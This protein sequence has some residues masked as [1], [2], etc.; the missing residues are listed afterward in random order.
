MHLKRPDIYKPT[1]V[2][3]I[4]FFFQQITGGYAVIFYAINLFLKIG[5][6]FGGHIDE[7]GAMLMLGVI[8]FFMSVF[9]AS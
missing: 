6:N 1:A 8:R 2:L 5:G 9:T 3:I 7:Y 4:L